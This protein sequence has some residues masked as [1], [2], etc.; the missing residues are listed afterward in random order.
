MLIVDI[1]ALLTVNLLDFLD[2]VVVNRA[3][4]EDAEDVMRVE[5][6]FV[7]LEAL[8]DL[9][10]VGYADAGG[11]SELVRTHLAGLRIDNVDR[12]DG[13]ALGL[14]D[15]N[16]AADLC[17]GRC[18]L[19][20][21]CLEQLFDSRKT[22]RN[23][24]TC[25]A[26]GMEGTHG[27]LGAR[28]ADG[29]RCDDTDSL[30]LADR[31]AHCKVDAV[32]VA[33]NAL[34]RAAL[35]YGADLHA[36]DACLDDLVGIV[37]VHHLA[38]RNDDY[39]G[40]R[41]ADVIDRITAEQTLTQRLD[42]LVAFLDVLDPDALGR[43][44][45]VL[46]DDNVLRNVYQTAGQ[47]TGVRGTKCGIGHA[48]S[49]AAGRDEVFEGGQTFTE[50]GLDRDFDGLTGG[51]SHQAS[52]TCQL[53]DLV[54][55]A[56]C[57]GIRHH[58][59]RVVAL[60]LHVVLELCSN[61][62]G[63]LFPLGYGQTIALLVGDK[64]ALVLAVDLSDLLLGNMDHLV[65]AFRNKHIGNGYGQSALGG[66][67]VAHRL[68]GVK[69]LGG[70]VEAVNTDALVD[71][72]SE[73]L[74]AA[75]EHDFEVELLGRV[76]TVYETE[77]LRNALV[78]DQAARG[79]VYDSG[80]GLAAHLL[81]QT[82]LDRRMDADN[83]LVISHKSLIDVAEYL[84]GA[85]LG[86]AVDGQIVGA[87]DHILRRDSNRLAVLRLEQVV[88]GQHQQTGLSLCLCGQRNVNCHLVAVE[89]GVECGTYQRMQ[90]DGAA[91]NENR[92]ERLNAQTVQGR[93]TVQH[94]R[95]TL[96]D[97]FEHVP[98]LGL[99]ALDHLLG[100]LDV[101]GGAVLDQLLHDEG[102]EQLERHFLRQTALVDLEVRTDDDNRTAGVVNTLAEQ[103]L[104]EAAL[105]ALQHIG[106][107]LECA[108]VR[109]G[110]RAAAAAVV[111]ERVNRFLKHT[112]LVAHDDIRCAQLK[113]ALQTVVAVDDA[114]VQVVQVAR[115]EAAAVQLYHRT[116]LRRDD[117]NNVHDH[118]LRAVMRQAERL[119]DLKALDDAQTLL[120]GS[121][122]QLCGQLLGQLVEVELCE[123]LLDGL[124]AH[125]GTEIV[126]VLFA[127]IAVLGL[128]EDL[129]LHERR[130]AR[131]ND[132]IVGEVQDLLQNARA[133][134]EDQTHAGR[135]ALEV[136]DVRYRRCQL[137]V[138]HA[139]AANLG[140]G[141]LN[142]ALVADL[143]L[144]ADL[145][146]LA[147]VALPVL[148]WA[149]DTLAEQAVAFRLERAVVNG[150]GLFNF[151]VGPFADQVGGR[152][153]DLDG[154][155]RMIS[156]ILLRCSFPI[157]EMIISVRPAYSPRSSKSSP[158]SSP[159]STGLSSAKRSVS[160]SSASLM[161]KPAAVNSS[162]APETACSIGRT[163]SV[164]S[165]SSSLSSMTSMFS[166]ST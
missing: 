146:V 4:I 95:V 2:L 145:L 109:T 39:A 129:L 51:G 89:V 79:R 49:S 88:R 60:R 6:A 161:P 117:R 8:R 98:N 38:L 35:E 53:T 17:E 55:R 158:A 162:S 137:D 120:A 32:A 73:F 134:V 144:E 83:A 21:A 90:T 75:G 65:L 93:R 77:I 119:D 1:Y 154:V 67:L 57:T 3:R 115:C 11:R 5:R 101:G 12:L 96:D 94:D 71:D 22:L 76:R 52:H 58:M 15:G 45:V 135:N 7:Q 87:E 128:G 149:K 106:Q 157:H 91:L 68:D 43:A 151:T 27:K 107:R 40:L 47:V 31:S 48:L 56:S 141:D 103:V 124:R 108:V 18:L 24:R 156:H 139:L 102:L 86:V 19:R 147:A 97:A 92:L 110:D 136:P 78:E 54:D 153:T 165:S 20:A 63:G 37:L 34:A 30:A 28:L 62:L 25:D 74:L 99:C 118:P 9:L 112:L 126:L 150:F 125:A 33:A 140:L 163:Y 155:K 42:D 100:G 104:T 111:D 143:A 70:D 23:I 105:L 164:S 152:Q 132:N 41:I 69:H 46:A 14:L 84:A 26:A 166:S 80:L 123:Q 138:A 121:L 133:D 10:T 29:L 85:R 122:A 130:V 16:H 81:G 61:L 113:Q 64:A 44:A 114:A 116:D 50:V 142:A 66:V 159:S 127:H 160:P 59:N 72:L 36:G 131:I 82:N 13:G 148:G